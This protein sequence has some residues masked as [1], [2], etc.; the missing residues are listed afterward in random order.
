MNPGTSR[1]RVRS[2]T[3]SATTGRRRAAAARSRT[4]RPPQDDELD[5][6][7]RLMSIRGP[8]GDEA[9]VAQFVQEQ[10]VRA[11]AKSA[12]IKF[13]TAH[14]KTPQPGN[15]GN[16]VLKLPGTVKGKRRLLMAHMDT[17]PVCLGSQP[18][19]RGDQI[20]SQDPNTGVGADDRAG[21]AVVLQTALR[22]L[23]EQPAHPP[24]T[25]LWTIQEEI[26]LFGARYLRTSMLG[27]PG[28]AFNWD[29][30]SASK[31]TIGATGGYKT[32][33]TVTGIASHAGNAPENGV[34]A[35]AIAGLAL[36]DLQ[37]NGWHGLVLKHG[38]RGTTNVGVIEGGTATNVVTDRVVLRAEARSHDSAFRNQLVRQI[39]KAFE[40]AVRH[41]RS[42]TGKHGS[43]SF[44]GRL[45]YDSFRLSA[46]EPCVLAAKRAITATGQQPELYVTNGGLDA[47]WMNKH[48]IPTATLGCG[49]VNPHMTSEALHV[50]DFKLA[51]QIAWQLATEVNGC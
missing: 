13:D 1:K 35:I 42:A 46:D 24:L 33:I 36:A 21:V 7:M 19:R 2:A 37:E 40:S 18:R 4:T 14:K 49:Q 17:V 41:V 25:F 16:M 9:A 28:L 11:G 38:K 31:V 12:D 51:C 34:S 3:K 27:N 48:G 30:G 23:R 32:T 26:G 10:L 5:L 47:N 50:P 45:D 43:V 20:K 15:I 8:S 44:D 39:E 6:V 29:G 22:I